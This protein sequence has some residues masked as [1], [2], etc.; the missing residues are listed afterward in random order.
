MHI[1][2]GKSGLAAEVAAHKPAV[3]SC[4]PC[5]LHTCT[6]RTCWPAALPLTALR[7][8]AMHQ[9][10]QLS[11]ELLHQW[12]PG[13]AFRIDD[14]HMSSCSMLMAIGACRTD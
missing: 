10:E 2:C 12:P 9:H 4:M 14:N 6:M 11:K 3:R 1:L 5:A 7:C 13:P 8:A